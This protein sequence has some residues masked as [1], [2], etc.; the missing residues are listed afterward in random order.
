[1]GQD[2]SVHSLFVSLCMDNFLVFHL[3]F[4]IYYSVSLTKAF[5]IPKDF[6]DT[7]INIGLGNLLKDVY[8]SNS[9]L[10]K[11]WL[12]NNQ[13]LQG[14]LDVLKKYAYRPFSSEVNSNIIDPRTY[15]YLRD[16]IYNSQSRNES[17]ALVSTWILNLAE[18][19]VSFYKGVTM[20]F[21]LNN[22]DLTVSAN[23]LYGLT[24]ALLGNLITE[25]Q[26]DEDIQMIY[27]NTTAVIAWEISHNF[28]SRPD[29]ALTY[30]PS[31][32]TFLWFTS[33]TL[34]LLNRFDQLPLP[35]LSRVRSILTTVMK[36]SATNYILDRMKTQHDGL[37]YLDDFLG[38]GDKDIFGM[39]VAAHTINL[40]A[41]YLEIRP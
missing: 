2:S 18:D 5:Y 40:Y 6:D 17:L 24:A 21:H 13:N 16:F 39:L 37:V 19:K 27:E 34:N 29:L 22:V 15:F 33:R 41:K 14:V 4:F 35:V 10:Y 32:Y 36:D 30:Y 26:F 3:I 38:D 9:S 31:V 7:F 23:T 20:P 8:N 28:S 1:M 25:D 12:S 11:K